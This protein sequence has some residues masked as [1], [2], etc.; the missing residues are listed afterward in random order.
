MYVSV[1]VCV[2]KITC[3][4]MKVI[5]LQIQNFQ[6]LI[7]GNL[8]NLHLQKLRDFREQLDIVHSYFL[9]R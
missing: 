6:E 7:K 2:E 9:M 5:F 1:C 3:I 4:K 8:R